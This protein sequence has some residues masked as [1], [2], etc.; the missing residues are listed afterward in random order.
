MP[1]CGTSAST[2]REFCWRKFPNIGS[3]KWRPI[4]SIVDRVQHLAEQFDAYMNEP[5]RQLIGAYRARQHQ[6]PTT[7]S[8]TSVRN[9]AFITRCRF[10]RADLVYSRVIILSRPVIWACRW[11]PSAC[12]TITDTSDNDLIPSGGRKSSTVKL[13]RRS[14]RWSKSRSADGTPLHVEV[15]IRDRTVHAQVWRANI[16]RVSLYLLDT[17]IAAN[18]GN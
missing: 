4:P 10:T 15:L 13:T 14:Y 6:T 7:R 2:I 3:R 8:H 9:M 12:F 1:S 16:G 18:A 11:L 5:A 17:K